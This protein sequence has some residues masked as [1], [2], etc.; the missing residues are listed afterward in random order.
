MIAANNCI[1]N[2]L[3]VLFSSAAMLITFFNVIVAVLQVPLFVK[4]SFFMLSFILLLFCFIA[5]NTGNYLI[6][7]S[8]KSLE[9]NLTSTLKN[10]I[11][12]GKKDV[13][14]QY[15]LKKIKATRNISFKI[16]T[17]YKL[18]NKS[19]LIFYDAILNYTM[20][21]FVAYKQIQG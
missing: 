15:R 13:E 20:D 3:L 12:K 6:C 21:F 8:K 11:Y 10:S 7:T 14:I 5:F 16:G 18:D 19:A 1:A 9:S 17:Y 4:L 2:V